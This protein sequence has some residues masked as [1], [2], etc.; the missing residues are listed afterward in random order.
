V[1]TLEL[2]EKESEVVAVLVR[3]FARHLGEDVMG[4]ILHETGGIILDDKGI[5]AL[6][7]KIESLPVREK[8][9]DPDD[10]DGPIIMGVLLDL[11]GLVM[12]QN[13][14]PSVKILE[15]LTQEQLEEVERWCVAVHW[16]ASD[17][18]DKAGPMPAYL[19][20]HLPEGH[21]YKTWRVVA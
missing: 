17:N 15:G 12:A 1:P 20:E 21:P 16:G 3:R 2:D 6:A 9:R 10:V 11:L 4:A 18:P 8:L 14:V 7:N 13:E 19:R 5:V